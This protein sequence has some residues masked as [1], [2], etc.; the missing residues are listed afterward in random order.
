MIF[1]Q[2]WNSV[3]WWSKKTW[4]ILPKK[5]ITTMKLTSV[6]SFKILKT[7]KFQMLTNFKNFS[8]FQWYYAILRNTK[9]RR[10]YKKKL[11]N[12]SWKC[13]KTPFPTDFYSQF[14]SE[15]RISKICKMKCNKM[16][17]RILNVVL[18]KLASRQVWST[19]EYI[20]FF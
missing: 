16:C 18:N 17:P 15:N 11:V 5:W 8:W 20:W 10:K 7:L 4:N 12:I 3:R 9:K 13:S 2:I 19:N 1:C 14:H 6:T